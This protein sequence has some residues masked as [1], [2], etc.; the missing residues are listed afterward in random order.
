MLKRADILPSHSAAVAHLYT[1]DL[2]QRVITY[3]DNIE[4]IAPE[5]LEGLLAHW[6]FVPPQDTLLQVLRGSNHI[7]IAQN[8]ES[9]EV[10]GFVA[11]ISDGV[12][13]GYIS[14]L[15]VRPAHRNKG[16]GSELMRRMLSKLEP[17]YGTYLGCTPELERFYE[18]L[19]FQKMTAMS[20]RRRGLKAG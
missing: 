19:G 13:C 1:L 14:H 20:K 8:S 10:L 7:L 3:I 9:R 16:I 6:D 4:A 15:A 5:Q 17:L 2:Q 11:A 18:R 12:S